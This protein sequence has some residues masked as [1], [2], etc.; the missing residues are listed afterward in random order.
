VRVVDDSY[1]ASPAAV[2]RA[3]DTLAATPA[4]RRVA[5]IGEMRELGDLADA[6]HADCGAAVARAGVD[7]L[8]A[9][10]GAPVDALARGAA[11]AGLT[12]GQIVRFAD[13][14]SAADAIAGLVTAGDLVLVKGS[15]GTR[16]DIVADRLKGRA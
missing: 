8:V 11:A 14:A 12:A 16:M 4:T 6:L 5:A 7:L 2:V 9:V 13:S 10:G 3:L 1:N 15:R